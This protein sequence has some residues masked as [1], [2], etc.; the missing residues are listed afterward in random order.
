MRILDLQQGTPEWK[1]H[2]KNARNA[3]EMSIIMGCCKQVKMIE[4]A[5]AKAFNKPIEHS[6]YVQ[7]IIFRDGH[8]IEEIA[9]RKIEETLSVELFPVVCATDEAAEMQLSCSLDGITPNGKLI[10]ECKQENLGKFDSLILHKIPQEDFWQ[11]CQCMYITGADHIVYTLADKEGKVTAKTFPRSYFEPSFPLMLAE[12]KNFDDLVEKLRR[13]GSR[14]TKDK[15][16]EAIGSQPSVI[17]LE[18]DFDVSIRKCNVGLY[19]NDVIN[20]INSIRTD[21]QTDQDFADAN[22]AIKWCKGIKEKVEHARKLALSKSKELE[23]MFAALQE[24]QQLAKNK[25]LALTKLKKTRS[26]EIREG[27]VK[28]H[29][30]QVRDYI[31]AANESIAP[32]FLPEIN[33]RDKII[34]AMKN[35]SSFNSLQ[36]A[37][38][39]AVN[40]IKFEISEKLNEI[41]AN[42]D[43]VKYLSG[44]HLPLFPDLENLVHLSNDKFKKTVAE[45]IAAYKPKEPPPAPP[46]KEHQPAITYK[47]AKHEQ[48][49]EKPKGQKII[50]LEEYEEWIDCKTFMICLHNAGVDN[51]ENYEYAQDNYKRIRGK[52]EGYQ[53][54]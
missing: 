5:E 38:A 20:A 13:T 7:D 48:T 32:Y 8:E 14:L 28:E 17:D 22:E 12:W 26:Q 27:I 2:R 44:D 3:S 24:I 23:D 15:A 10:W 50:S 42:T 34:G 53:Y 52:E 4:L 31:K 41:I 46:P 51:W 35:K 16:P 49:E 54:F 18:F 43:H 47:T 36:E 9:R 37:A 25:E 30:T 11:C 45:R 40:S 19:R 29:E 39:L 6:D 33:A 1:E 21:L